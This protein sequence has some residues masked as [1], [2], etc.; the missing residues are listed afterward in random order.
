MNLFKAIF[1]GL[2]KIQITIS[3]VMKSILLGIINIISSAIKAIIKFIKYI[4]DL[5]IKLIKFLIKKYLA[6]EIGITKIILSI[7]NFM[8]YIRLGFI[9]AGILYIAFLFDA[10][11]GWAILG[12]GIV[13]IPFGW[14]D[15][16]KD[17]EEIPSWVAKIINFIRKPIQ[18]LV[19]FI[20]A[21]L[22]S[23]FFIYTNYSKLLQQYNEVSFNIATFRSQYDFL[24]FRSDSLLTWFIYII[25]F[26]V[27]IIFIYKM[28]QSGKTSKTGSNYWIIIIVLILFI[29]ISILVS[30]I[31][32]YKSKKISESSS[33]STSILSYSFDHY[34]FGKLNSTD[35]LLIKFG[36]PT[37]VKN[38]KNN[39]GNSLLLNNTSSDMY[40]QIE[41]KL[42]IKSKT[43]TINFDMIAS[44]NNRTILTLLLDTPEIRTIK[45]F[46][47]GLLM[48]YL[49][50]GRKKSDES[51]YYKIVKERYPLNKWFNFNIN[52][53]ITKEIIG[54]KIDG[55]EVFSTK[56]VPSRND[57]DAIR[58]SVPKNVKVAIDN[59]RISK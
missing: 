13:A 24:E 7:I 5:M 26:L 34:S 19:R 51:A 41:L 59:L 1:I 45:F 27:I 15:S 48:T 30:F 16:K 47:K 39:L 12:L 44:G 11:L 40:D 17:E 36:S 2:Q 58:F 53:D 57:I 14:N 35:N 23:L 56:F 38:Y 50:D 42:G 8:I 49:M 55:R 32:E 9:Y 28:I 46:E 10:R 21:V 29:V 43:Y 22:P 33:Y 54:F 4:K 31:K 6:L 18:Y 37:I 25:L 52:I 3:I 20:I